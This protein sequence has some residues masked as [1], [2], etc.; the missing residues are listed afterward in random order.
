[1]NKFIFKFWIILIG[2]EYWDAFC[3]LTIFFFL[4]LFESSKQNQRLCCRLRLQL[5][6]LKIALVLFAN[7]SHI[8]VGDCVIKWCYFVSCCCDPINRWLR[9]SKIFSFKQWY[10]RLKGSVAANNFW[11]NSFFFITKPWKFIYLNV[12]NFA[13]FEKMKNDEKKLNWN[14][15]K[16]L[17]W[18]LRKRKKNLKCA[19]KARKWKFCEL[20]KGKKIFTCV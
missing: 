4:L 20:R 6:R 19:E 2:R 1:M 17:I 15:K 7:C 9:N 14:W 3:D 5:N 12:L 8:A 16:W 11:L 13:L 18:T 10:L